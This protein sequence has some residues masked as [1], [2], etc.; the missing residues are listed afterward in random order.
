MHRIGGDDNAGA[1]LT[2]FTRLLENRYAISKVLQRKRGGEPTDA[3]PDN[4]YPRE[5]DVALLTFDH[6][7]RP[8]GLD[9]YHER[10]TTRIGNTAVAMG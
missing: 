8:V 7:K 5:I 3:A 1:N 4:R 10:P 6:E 2:E 9:D